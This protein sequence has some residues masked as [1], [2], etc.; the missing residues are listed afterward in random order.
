MV[1]VPREGEILRLGGAPDAAG[2]E[3][4]GARPVIVVS[5]DQFNEAGLAIACAIT[6]HQGRA[7]VPRNP[8][9]VAVPRGLPVTGMIRTD[10]VKT[11]DWR[12]RKAEIVCAVDRQTLL[13]VRGR[14]RTLLG[15]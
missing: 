11:I 8:L 4:A 9:E 15:I 14:L 13:A 2:H 10:Q 7:E 12:A 6:T 1:K 3:L 5:V